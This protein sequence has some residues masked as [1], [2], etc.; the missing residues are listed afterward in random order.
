M[1]GEGEGPEQRGLLSPALSSKSSEEERE[2]IYFGSFTQ[3]G[4]CL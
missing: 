3:D 2:N 4:D 1:G